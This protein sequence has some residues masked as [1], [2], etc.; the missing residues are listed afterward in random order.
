MPLEAGKGQNRIPPGS[1][2]KGSAS[3]LI[4]AVRHVRLPAPVTVIINL[5]FGATTSVNGAE[6]TGGNWQTTSPPHATPEASEGDLGARPGL[7]LLDPTHAA[8][9]Q[10]ATLGGVSSPH[11]HPREPSGSGQ[12]PCR[13]LLSQGDPNLNPFSL[14]SPRSPHHR[15]GVSPVSGTMLRSISPIPSL[16]VETA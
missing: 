3:T 8:H 13:A 2:Q 1:L 9:L 15:Y 10:W 14:S 5:H 11:P 6:V 7:P 16:M 4:L 12:I